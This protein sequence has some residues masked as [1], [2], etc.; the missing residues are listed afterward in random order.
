MI[1]PLTL[2][3]SSKNT[4]LEN[5]EILAAEFASGMDYGYEMILNKTPDN[6][7]FYCC[8]LQCPEGA[9]AS[10]RF[11][12]CPYTNTTLFEG[13]AVNGV[14]FYLD[15]YIIEEY[16]EALINPFPNPRQRKDK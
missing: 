4:L 10:L 12:Y 6:W 8:T 1:D 11:R 13:S 9:V 14:D 15:R 3:L 2:P 5:V 16:A 7:G